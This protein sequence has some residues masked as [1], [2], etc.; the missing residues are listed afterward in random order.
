[1]RCLFFLLTLVLSGC[2]IESDGGWSS[3]GGF[4]YYDEYTVGC[5][6]DDYE[7]AYSEA[8]CYPG[9]VSMVICHPNWIRPGCVT[10]NE[11]RHEFG[12]CYLTH[13]CEVW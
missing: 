7:Y 4:G 5:Y 13:V 11:A 3:I 10:P 1:M 2:I 6:P 8:D 12:G 9:V